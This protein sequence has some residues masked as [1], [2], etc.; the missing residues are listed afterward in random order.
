[1]IGKKIKKRRLELGMTQ[2]ELSDVSEI[3]LRSIQR[4]E[5]EKVNPRLHTLKVLSEHLETDLIKTDNQLP[6]NEKKI[7]KIILSIGLPIL[8]FLISLAYIS[9]SE[10]FPETTFEGIIFYICVFVTIMIAELIIW[11]KS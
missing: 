7:R 11:K 2:Q 5:T 9:Q 6:K 4:I 10:N 8:L 1:M 3:S